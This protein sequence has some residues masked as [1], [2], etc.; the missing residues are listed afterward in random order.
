MSKSRPMRNSPQQT[1]SHL[2][3]N[4]ILNAAAEVFEKTGYE[5]ASTEMIAKRART[6]I[7]SL[8]RFFPDK[9]AI[10]CSLA[11]KYA[12]QMEKMF[13]SI[14]ESFTIDTSIKQIVSETIDSFDSF[15]NNQPGCRV[16]MLQ[17]LV[18]NEIKS[19]NDKVDDKIAIKLKT[20]FKLKNPNL[21]LSRCKISALICIEIANTL[22]FWSLK[23][24]HEYKQQIVEETKQVLISYLKTLF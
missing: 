16:I 12:E 5:N 22:Q 19:V 11:E 7:G 3:Y 17:S 4:Q 15:Y 14:L 9:A 23:E 2:K 21:E 13:E 10:A 20:F 8:Y 6:S 1:R 24:S 18:S